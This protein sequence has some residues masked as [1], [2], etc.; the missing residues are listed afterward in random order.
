MVIRE[1]IGMEYYTPLDQ[2][3]K[4]KLFEQEERFQKILSKSD[5]IHGNPEQRAYDALKEFYE[6]FSKTKEN[7]V[8]YVISYGANQGI[9]SY[10]FRIMKVCEGFYLMHSY[11]KV[12][13]ELITL[14]HYEDWTQPRIRS[15]IL[16]TVKKILEEEKTGEK[17]N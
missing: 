13:S 2:A 14:L 6:A 5:G 15:G 8:K 11:K 12:C 16:V 10:I 1:S 4:K 7:K 3:D 17:E 9:S